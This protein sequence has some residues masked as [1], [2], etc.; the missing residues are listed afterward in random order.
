MFTD[1][2]A[3]YNTKKS[4]VI[5]SCDE[6][7]SST[8]KMRLEAN[9]YK[10]STIHKTILNKDVID[11][12]KPDLLLYDLNDLKDNND[13]KQACTQLS[14]IDKIKIIYFGTR[15][16]IKHKW[17]ALS[18]GLA[19]FVEIPYQSDELLSQIENA[20]LTNSLCE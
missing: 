15:Q 1:D 6:I 20:L 12:I 19:G 3:T 5:V 11:N 17:S 7:F 14:S 9:G 16:D 18:N 4:I 13:N 8:V 2:Y 10:A